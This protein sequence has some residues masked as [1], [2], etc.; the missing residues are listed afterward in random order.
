MRNF[1]GW[2]ALAVA[3]LLVA[4]GGGQAAAR[5]PV[6]TRVSPTSADR[7]AILRAFDGVFFTTMGATPDLALEPGSGGLV[8]V[9]VPSG[10]DWARVTFRATPKAP[11]ETAAGLRDGHDQSFFSK[12]PGGGWTW[13]GY[14]AQ[15]TTECG[16]AASIPSA[17]AAALGVHRA[18][19]STPSPVAATP[20]PSAPSAPSAGASPTTLSSGDLATLLS[21]FVT[22]KNSGPAGQ[23]LTPSAIVTAPSAPPRAALVPGGEWAVVVYRP[24]SGAP[25]PLTSVQLEDGAGT[26]F[27][28]QGGG[29]GWVLR[30]LAGSRFCTGAAAAHVPPAVLALWGRSC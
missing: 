18:A 23:V 5:P 2:A 6:P 9:V 25:E 11:A 26:A 22:A 21:Q 30:G 29:R 12:A 4:C 19:C 3:G 27:F 17:V 14:V 7:K 1:G 15:Y 16:T 13:R 8:E 20:A 10:V 24:A 28:F